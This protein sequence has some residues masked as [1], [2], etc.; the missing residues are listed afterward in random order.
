MSTPQELVQLICVHVSTCT[1]CHTLHVPNLDAIGCQ[2]EGFPASMG[3]DH[4]T[5]AL[6]CKLLLVDLLR[7]VRTYLISESQYESYA[8]QVGA[9]SHSRGSYSQR[10]AG[11]AH[12]PKRASPTNAAQCSVPHLTHATTP[13]PGPLMCFAPAAFGG[14]APRVC[15]PADGGHE[16]VW[17]LTAE[18]CCCAG[19]G[20]QGRPS[21]SSPAQ[22]LQ[23]LQ[24]AVSVE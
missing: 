10:A 3:N 15:Q 1:R 17:C 6:Q 24:Q 13:A 23:M 7:D 12:K 9:C 18:L 20:R 11:M 8:E 21:H 19:E 16:P 2:D 14:Q 4:N 5:A 22:V